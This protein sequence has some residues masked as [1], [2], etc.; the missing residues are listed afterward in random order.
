MKIYNFQ[1]K[2]SGGGDSRATTWRKFFHNLNWPLIGKWAFRAAAIG[3]L[4]IA[5]LFI[6]YSRNLPDPNRLLG[7]NVPESTKIYARDETLLYEVHGEFKRT[8]VNLD[9]ISPYLKNATIAAEDKN[10]YRH[11]GISVTGL[12]R[13]V[14]VDIIHGEKRQGGSTIT[15]Q[16]VKNAV[17]TRDKSFL[18][19]LKEI[20]ISIELEA[21]F[22]KDDI[23]KLYLNEIPYGRNAYGVE[24]ASQTYFNKSAKDLSLAESAY[25]A[26]LP[27]APSY[28]NPSGPN[29][30]DL[31]ARQKYI[32]GQMKDQGYI[33][34]E[35]YQ[36]ATNDQVAFE[37]VKDSIKAAHFV[38][39]VQDYLADKYGE[40]TLEEGGL[41]VYTTLDPR[42]QEIAETAVREGAAKNESSN[43]Y[44]AALVAMDPKTGQI[45]AMV[46]SKDY[47]GQSQPANCIAGKTCLFEP[48]VNVATTYQ[49]PGS[50]FKP[51]AYVTAFGRDFKYAPASL[52]LDVKTNF[53][54]YSPNNF[55][56]SQNGPVSMRKALAGSLNIP[57]VK[58][59]ALVGPDNVIKTARD[60]GIT[61]PFQDCGLALVLGGCDVKLV[62]HTAGYA[63]LANKGKREDQTAILKVVSKEGKVLEEYEEHSEQVLDPQA[64]YELT[65]IMSDNNA[66]SYVFGTNSALTLGNRPVAAKTGTTQD[67]RDGWTLGFTPSLVA[68]VWTGNNNNA[69]MRK[70]AV[71]MAGP[72]WN[73]FMKEALAG[74]P[75][76][77]F[78]RPEGI[79]E[80]T[81]DAVSGKLPTQY[82][83]ETKTEIFA[84]YAVP[85]DHDDV[86]VP[87]KIDT[88][89][90]LPADE[91]TP[92]DRVTTEIY[93]VLHS[94]KPNNPSWEDPVIAWAL[95]NGYKYPPGSGINNTPPTPSGSVSITSPA[96]NAV[97]SKLPMQVVVNPG[98][99]VNHV[100]I[101]I[102]GTVVTTINSSPYSASI[103]QKY[104]DGNHTVS[105]RVYY[106]NNTNASD[107]ITVRYALDGALLMNSPSDGSTVSFPV[108]LAA[109]SPIQYNSVS[110]YYQSGNTTKLIGPATQSQDNGSYV[111]S[112]IW[113]LPPKSGSYRVYARTNN[114]LTSNKVLISVP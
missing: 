36:K 69:P 81:V 4:L 93:T 2:S 87:V 88:L 86:H 41:K 102:D 104:S 7:R 99:D 95:A 101:A 92:P 61:A 34:D 66:R 22:K 103:N 18:R 67:F 1:T 29:F 80:V 62:D 45:L 105:A 43:G 23:L 108:S 110:F 24:A 46:G 51:Y 53:G 96:D 39:Y 82:T 72:I 112:G 19:K 47:F 14:I 40:Q 21:R 85:N 13:S 89:T 27:Q 44:N 63:T 16:F 78:E 70:D 5:F 94:E 30:D 75:I 17:L 8:L 20:I 113:T 25:L 10:F 65:N 97:I 42:L 52:L 77:Q 109:E 56:L 68:G 32:L 106:N 71:V 57:A 33:N 26:A 73:R 12:A 107:S 59:L 76:E 28:Y 31:Q 54:N 37:K 6:Y 114:G 11:A 48:N 111:Y 100:D 83:P 50:S 98:V 74:T 84:D 58:T 9:Q 3:I 55:N 38:Q 79:R 49:Q 15:Q 91:N 90:G 64:V 35:E 60:V